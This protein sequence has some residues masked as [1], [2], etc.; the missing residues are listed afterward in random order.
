M[1]KKI[2]FIFILLLSS[3]ILSYGQEEVVFTHGI[4]SGDVRD[5]EAVLWTRVDREATVI[6]QVSTDCTFAQIDREVLGEALVE[7]DFTVKMTV[8]DL[9]SDTTYCYRFRSGSIISNDVG[10][11]RTAPGEDQAPSKNSIRFAFSG[12]S[13]GCFRDKDFA[14]LRSIQKEDIDFWVY[15]GDTIYSEKD[16]RL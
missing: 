7:N 8:T 3:P 4:A 15:L 2:I 16:V 14:V 11:F 10:Q 9:E 1:G 5:N 12:D 13:D 6:A